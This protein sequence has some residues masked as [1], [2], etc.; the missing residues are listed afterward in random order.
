METQNSIFSDEILLENTDLDLS[1]ALLKASSSNEKVV[2][3]DDDAHIKTSTD[4]KFVKTDDAYTKTPADEK[5]ISFDDANIIKIDDPNIEILSDKNVELVKLPE[6]TDPL[7]L[8]D[9]LTD[10][11]FSSL[12][13]EAPPPQ[14]RD[15]GND[16]ITE[17]SPIIFG[18]DNPNN[19]SAAS[20]FISTH[21]WGFGGNDSLTGGFNNDILD[22]GTGDDLLNGWLGDDLLKGGAG[23]DTLDGSYGYDTLD[24]GDGIDTATY[25][26][27]WGGIKANLQ[28]ETVT[29][30]NDEGNGTEYLRSI[31]NVVGTDNNDEI[32]GNSADNVLFGENGNDLLSGGD[33]NDILLGGDGDD[34]LISGNGYD[35]LDGGTGYDIAQIVGDG[36]IVFEKNWGNVGN[37]T[38]TTKNGSYNAVLNNV[39]QIQ[40]IGGDNDDFILAI[41]APVPLK[42]EGRGGNDYLIGGAFGNT[43]EGGAGNDVLRGNNGDD[44]LQGSD[45][46]NL[47]EK[48]TLLGGLGADTF[49]LGT[50]KGGS[51]YLGDGFATILDFKW[52]EGDK[53]QVVGSISDYRLDATQ[54]FSG[55]LALDTAIYRGNDLIAVVQ[56]T[57]DVI[58]SWD[59][60]FV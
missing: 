1:D 25:K 52:W 48:D 20:S 31:E 9:S 4:D 22:G 8:E 50:S 17:Y 23:N 18:D 39:E 51:F 46:S 42:L 59:F 45:N 34:I 57:T 33:G 37:V 40:L 35:Q 38:Y 60:K 12:L 11:D 3:T 54:N 36:D 6:N 30:F 56:G 41:E 10:I 28:T 43:L 44:I 19:L 29:F 55:N 15:T 16:T 2:K 14:T 7:T 24:G 21:I 58:P 26:F 5:L 53:I 49:V 13:G 47:V 32:I 27:W